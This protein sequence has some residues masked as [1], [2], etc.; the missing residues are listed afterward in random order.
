M[1]NIL[2]VLG[3][4]TIPVSSARE[5]DTLT[6]NVQA[7]THIG[8]QSMG[9]A[10][11]RAGFFPWINETYATDIDSVK[12]LMMLRIFSGKPHVY[13]AIA[14][15]NPQAHEQI[16]QYQKS[17]QELLTLFQKGNSQ[18]L[19]RYLHEIRDTV[20]HKNTDLVLRSEKSVINSCSLNEQ[21]CNV[22]SNSHLSLL[23]MAHTWYS[24]GIN[25]YEHMI[26]Q[27]PPF[28]FRLGIVER[29]FRDDLLLYDVAHCASRNPV[30]LKHDAIFVDAVN[31]WVDVVTRRDE[32]EYTKLFLQTQE[33]FVSHLAQGQQK[34]S[35]L[36]KYFAN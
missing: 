6:A 22:L 34:S 2:S 11:S 16:I 21:N 33:F 12:H 27:T 1:Q 31:S 25:P 36:I 18:A 10:W 32:G 35:D 17:A 20:F 24:L 19:L 8:F 4:R 29:L 23:A 28:K 3:Y 26:C 9:T 7:V 13:S 15:D 30:V 14:F 5:H